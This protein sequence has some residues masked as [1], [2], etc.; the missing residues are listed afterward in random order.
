LK[1]ITRIV[2]VTLPKIVLYRRPDAG[3]SSMQSGNFDIRCPNCNMPYLLGTQFCIGVGGCWQPITYPAISDK[4]N[5]VK[6]DRDRDIALKRR[7]NVTAKYVNQRGGEQGSGVYQHDLPIIGDESYFPTMSVPQNKKRA[8]SVPVPKG[9]ATATGSSSSQTPVQ[10]TTRAAMPK[11]VP[12]PA[13]AAV[14][15]NISSCNASLRQWRLS[16]LPGPPGPAPRPQSASAKRAATKSPPAKAR[17]PGLRPPPPI[18]PMEIMPDDKTIKKYMLRA[19]R[20]VDGTRYRGHTHRYDED[21]LYRGQ[22]LNNNPPTPRVLRYS[23]GNIA[24][25][26]RV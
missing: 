20:G 1:Y 15:A 21:L 25:D 11:G 19:W 8:A 3:R 5:F 9:A 23:N 16:G 26:K 4:Y 2:M 24:W 22:M 12:T 7:Y 6:D 18:N 13:A 14:A 17:P 10:G